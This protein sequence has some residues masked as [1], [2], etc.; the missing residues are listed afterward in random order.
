MNLVRHYRDKVRDAWRVKNISTIWGTKR[1]LSEEDIEEKNY[2]EAKRE[3]TQRMIR[4]EEVRNRTW[5]QESWNN[6]NSCN[7]DRY[8]GRH[9]FEDNGFIIDRHIRTIIV[10][11]V[12]SHQIL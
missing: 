3:N 9:Q 5:S 8:S 6:Y 7:N 12:L 2:D 10:A 11:I 1:F 4:F